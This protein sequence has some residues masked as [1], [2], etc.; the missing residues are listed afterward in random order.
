[1]YQKR[2]KMAYISPTN[3]CALGQLRADN[4]TTMEELKTLLIEKKEELSKNWAGTSTDAGGQ[5]TLFAVTTEE[6]KDLEMLLL[7]LGFESQFF[8]D[9]R[10]G[11]DNP[12]SNLCFLTLKL[13]EYD[14]P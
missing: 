1:M 9:R 6:E 12:K 2:K 14:E 3:C 10:N 5:T 13:G 11:Y 7:D 4:K 8:F